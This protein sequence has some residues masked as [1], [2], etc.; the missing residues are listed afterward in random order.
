MIKIVVVIV[1]DKVWGVYRVYGVEREGSTYELAS[2]AH[3]SF[4]IERGAYERPA[5]LFDMELI[6]SQ[7]IGLSV[8]G[9]EGKSRTPVQRSDGG[10]FRQIT[11][12]LPT[13]P[14]EEPTLRLLQEEA[15]ATSLK[16]SS[17]A[18][19][20]RLMTAPKLPPQI[21]TLSTVFIRNPDVISEVLIRA[22]GTCELCAS[23]A[24]FKRKS[25]DT[26]YLEVHHRVKLADGG[27]DTVENAMAVCPNCHRRE[28]YGYPRSADPT[29]T[30]G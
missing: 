7:A 17:D 2:V 10:F 26:P 28:H 19:R 22:S 5:K 11:V 20:K 30:K 18:R 3:R 9:W 8:T 21:Q 13:E 1:S 29:K 24:P 12:D 23:S 4:D 16:G 14:F 25:D 27:K 6:H 15:V